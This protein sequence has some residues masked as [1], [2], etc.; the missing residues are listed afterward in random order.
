MI[1]EFLPDYGT[2]DDWNGNIVHYFAEQQFPILPEILW[3]D[4][5][6]AIS[7]SPVF[8]KYSVPSP[9]LFTDWQEWA[10]VFTLSVNGVGS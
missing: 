7:V 1:I 8:D 4:V 10:R 6:R 9:D 3:Q 5:A 2:W